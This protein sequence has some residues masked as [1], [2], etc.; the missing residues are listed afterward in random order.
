LSRLLPS[1][2][3]ALSTVFVVKVRIKMAPTKSHL[4]EVMLF[5]FK[6]GLT[7]AASSAKICD[8]YGPDTTCDRTVRRWFER[9]RDGDTTVEDN[10]RSGRPSTVDS[11]A[12]CALADSNGHLTIDDIAN[13][14]DISHGSVHRHLTNA[15]Y[16][17]RA[18]VW[19]PHDLSERNMMERINMCALLLEKDKEA[20]F[21]MNLI[22]GDEKWIVYKNVT[23]RRSWSHKDSEPT[24]VAKPSLTRFKV[25]LSVWWDWKGVVHYELLPRNETINSAKYCQQ[26]N[27]L[28]IAVAQKRPELN[29]H[30]GVAF[31]HDNARP[32]TSLETCRHL[33]SFAWD[34]LPHPAYS[35]DLAPSDY[36]LFRSIQ[37]SLSGLEFGNENDVKLHLDRFFASKNANFWKKG[38]FSLTE[39]W[40]RVIRQGGTYIID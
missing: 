2:L 37:N 16:I 11:A 25:M 32:H 10:D 5:H 27:R 20:P 15:G 26:L 29:T 36:H 14:L 1:P 8:V 24:T 23:R 39:R 38:I 34:V 12:I 13:M 3:R 35:P 30:R 28:K 31:Q 40:E 4:R 18:D 7:A 17:N 33:L 19:V 21:L 6:E 22:T 9:F